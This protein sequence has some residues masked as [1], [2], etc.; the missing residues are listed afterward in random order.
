VPRRD[1]AWIAALAGLAAL[2]TVVPRVAA[3]PVA[4]AVAV[5]VWR[6]PA[7][8]LHLA[9]FAAL[10]IR[11]SLDVFSE[12]RLGLG[13]FAFSPSVVFGAA[14]L[15]VALVLAVRRGR[16]GLRIWSDV[17]LLRA[18]VWLFAAYGIGV[19]SGWHWYG[20]VGLAEGMRELV[21]VASVVAAFLVVLWWVAV[22]PRAY[23]RG[24]AYLVIGTFAPIVVAL[25]QL[26]T[27]QGFLDEGVVR[28]LGTFSHP[29]NFAQY[30]VPFVLVAVAGSAASST[31][32]AVLR[33]GW[34]LGLSLLVAFTYS[35]TALLAL[36]IA[37]VLLPLLLAGRSGWG[38][39]MQG[40]V[41]VALVA[42]LGWWLVGDL[43]R[44]R[45]AGVNL[46]I[47][48]WEQVQQ[49]V[50]VNSF[51]WRLIDWSGLVRL[52]L[53]HPLVGHG[54]GMTAVLNPLVQEGTG[55]PFG[56]HDDFV[57]FFFETGLLGLACYVIY[58]VRLCAWTFGR[59]RAAGPA[60]APTAYAVTASLL[61]LF[62][63]TAGVTEL[64]VNTAT[65]HSLYGMLA[66]LT[67]PPPPGQTAPAP[68]PRR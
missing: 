60:T 58:G 35:R 65:L 63:F 48:A 27:G 8:A 31:G 2:A 13:P 38:G 56:A 23:G 49:G 40:A 66:L 51:T 36:A 46:G 24:W 53:E 20:A 62:F 55:L 45:F 21:R 54:G 57:K 17:R 32:F 67:I 15:W 22:E 64:A 25:I 7:V 6:R 47:W 12:R 41:V 43:I 29:S 30:L 44:E 39:L 3:L 10:A 68:A 50:S 52:G 34:A 61:S 14:L 37:L 11:P 9:A 42:A 59:A 18:H 4:A 5:A 33:L 19:Y 1:V 16:D 28:I 26:A